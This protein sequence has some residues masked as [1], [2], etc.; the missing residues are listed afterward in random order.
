MQINVETTLKFYTVNRTAYTLKIET[1]VE[2][3]GG[4]WVGTDVET[5]IEIRLVMSER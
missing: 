2:T 3:C 1:Y 4:T 5:R